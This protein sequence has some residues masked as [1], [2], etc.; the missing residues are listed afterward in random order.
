M[1]E[2]MD[3]ILVNRLYDEFYYNGKTLMVYGGATTID[4]R[5][6]L[7]LFGLVLRFTSEI[8][9]FRVI[10]ID[11]YYEIN[12]GTVVSFLY[13]IFWFCSEENIFN[14]CNGFFKFNYY[15]LINNMLVSFQLISLQF[16][17]VLIISEKILLIVIKKNT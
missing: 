8:V 14:S 13:V 1:E 10:Y 4:V 2:I 7:T 12:Y 17:I 16:S 15:R 6:T 5:K 9:K 3:F 11:I